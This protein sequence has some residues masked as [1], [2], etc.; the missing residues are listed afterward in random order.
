MFDLI[1]IQAAFVGL[2]GIRQPFDPAYQKLDVSF[3]TS[4]SGLY[5][6]DIS[7]YKTEYWIDTQDYK[8][9]TDTDLSLRMGQIR[10]G[11]VSSLLS[12]IFT[13]SS[14]IDRNKLYSQTF[15][16][17]SLIT[18]QGDSQTFY[19]YEIIAGQEKNLAF[20]ITKCTLE[21]VGTGNITI[22]LYNSSKTE[23]LF[24]QVVTISG[25][26]SLTEIELNW[27]VDSTMIPY[28]GSYFIGYY[29]NSNVQPIDRGYEAGDLMN[30][31]KGLDIERMKIEDN[32]LNLASLSYE[33][34][35]NGLN[36]DIT[37]YFDYTDLVLQNTFLFAKSFQ[38][39]WAINVM[40]S[41]SSS[42]RVNGKERLSK[43]VIAYIIRSIEGQS[44][45]DVLRIVGARE[46]LAGELVRLRE[47]IDKVKHGYFNDD[48]E[49]LTVTT[50]E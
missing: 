15:D 34:D 47:E 4:D 41:Y 45:K 1:K 50:N 5:L 13:E 35:H 3:E 24:S 32:F 18:Q 26:N 29:K 40:L 28:K 20:K 27:I 49:Y 48:S 46:L 7:N 19:G 11:A 22:Q 17:Q 14:Y 23:P 36:F 12:Q 9:I 10:D 43:E 38:M 39:T 25:A 37:T 44:G 30:S 21:M 16:R 33:S 8:D 31:I 2:V 42:T 6:D